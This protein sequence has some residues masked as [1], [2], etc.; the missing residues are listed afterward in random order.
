MENRNEIALSRFVFMNIYTRTEILG[1]KNLFIRNLIR[2]FD[3][4]FF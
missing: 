2:K 1:L 3:S 4:T